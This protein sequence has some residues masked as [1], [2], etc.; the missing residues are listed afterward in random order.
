MVIE[1]TILSFFFINIFDLYVQLLYLILDQDNINHCHTTE[2]CNKLGVLLSS[3]LGTW[4][5]K[6]SKLLCGTL[7]THA[8]TAGSAHHPTFVTLN[9]YVM[10][11]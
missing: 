3:A 7:M 1:I 9:D 5:H 2:I 10:S 8:C 11:H 4:M 6:P